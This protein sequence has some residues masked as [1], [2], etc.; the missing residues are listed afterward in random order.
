MLAGEYTPEHGVIALDGKK[1]TADDSNID[2]L[3][4]SCTIAYCPQFDA[5]FEKITVE[6]HLQ[7]YSGVRGLDWKSEATQKHINAIIRLLGLEKYRHKESSNLSGGYKRRLSL[8]V[9]MIGYPKVM[10][11]DEIT[12]GLDPG[13][14]RL[15]WDVLKPP[16]SHEGEYDVPAI[17]LSSHY[18]DE[19][20]ELGT[21]IGIMID[22]EVSTTGSLERLQERFCDSYFVELSMQTTVDDTTNNQDAILA[23]FE[24]HK[25]PDTTVYESLPYHLKLQVP[26]LTKPIVGTEQL[27]S[28]F[29]LL[30]SKKDSLGIKFYSVTMMNLEQ[31]FIDLSRKQFRANET[32]EFE[33][34][35][36]AQSTRSLGSLRRMSSS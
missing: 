26:F 13:A 6:A 23:A 17:L 33:R 20:Q 28:I 16:V 14:R 8:A 15:I 7:F 21:R 35:M 25:M 22:G 34:S 30:E 11:V 9:A 31:I 32:F 24:Q 10:M 19:C 5:L 4:R 29:E 1:M 3:Y 2:D 18:M 12:T 27:S 36:R